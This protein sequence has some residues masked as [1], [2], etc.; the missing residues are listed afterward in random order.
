MMGPE[1]FFTSIDASR[2]HCLEFISRGR[3]SLFTRE[4]LTCLTW[5]FMCQQNNPAKK[6][7]DF[8][9]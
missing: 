3:E 9:D 7:L 1:V 5:F 2:R 6:L 8:L 4:P